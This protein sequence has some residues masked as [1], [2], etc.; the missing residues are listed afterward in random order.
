ML[1]RLNEA[2]ANNEYYARADSPDY[3]VFHGNKWTVFAAEDGGAGVDVLMYVE[4]GAA[5]LMIHEVGPRSGLTAKTPKKSE[6]TFCCPDHNVTLVVGVGVMEPTE[7]PLIC[8]HIK[9]AEAAYIRRYNSDSI[10]ALT[11]LVNALDTDDPDLF[12]LGM[13]LDDLKANNRQVA[14]FLHL[15]LACVG[16]DVWEQRDGTVDDL[17][18]ERDTRMSWVEEQSA[19]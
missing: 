2:E 8:C 1:T 11:G 7:S 17:V 10:R 9:T 12:G 5:G 18:V 3:A 14:R 4:K 16:M 6:I 15:L 13:V 19:Y